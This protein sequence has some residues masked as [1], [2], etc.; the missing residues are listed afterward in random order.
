MDETIT[1]HVAALES[2]NA[3]TRAAA[4]NALGE[5]GITA[6]A[7]RP[8][9]EQ[10]LRGPDERARAE[11]LHALAKTTADPRTIVSVLRNVLTD[12]EQKSSLRTLATHLLR[13]TG[14]VGLPTL[15]ELARAGDVDT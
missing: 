7:A 2:T 8:F 6:Q 3:T 1:A 15:L 9:R 12:A 14:E 10:A 4:A 11:A 5:L 13:M